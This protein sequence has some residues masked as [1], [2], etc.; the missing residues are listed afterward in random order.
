M[1]GYKFQVIWIPECWAQ[2]SCWWGQVEEAGGRSPWVVQWTPGPVVVMM[3]VMWKWVS[4]RPLMLYGCKKKKICLHCVHIKSD[5]RPLLAGKG[6]S[7][8]GSSSN[9]SDLYSEGAWIETWQ[10]YRI[11][12]QKFLLVF[13][14]PSRIF[15][16][17]AS[18]SSLLQFAIYYHPVI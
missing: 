8:A 10:V 15:N 11:F 7:K 16:R 5:C 6:N 12:W 17:R 18:W 9:A 13:L 2:S 3:M 1:R 4:R 14:S